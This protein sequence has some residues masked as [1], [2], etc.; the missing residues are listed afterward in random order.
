M[1]FLF[2]GSLLAQTKCA[3]VAQAP[4]LQ[5]TFFGMMQTLV[6]GANNPTVNYF[7]MRTWDQSVGCTWDQI[8]LTP[9]TYTFTNCDAFLDRAQSVGATWSFVFGRTPQQQITTPAN[10][11]GGYVSHGGCAQKPKDLN[12]ANTILPNFVTAIVNHW[13]SRYPGVHFFIECVNE[14]DLARTWAND[15]GTDHGSMADLVTYCTTV[16]T[17]AQAIDPTIVMLGPSSSTYNQFG[18]HLYGGTNAGGNGYLTVAG[19]A[20]SFDVLNL[21]PYFYCPSLP[22]TVPETAIAG[23]TSVTALGVA[24]PVALSETNWGTTPAN[25]GMTDAQRE[26]WIGRMAMY[27]YNFG[28][29]YFWWYQWNCTSGILANCA[30]TMNGS[31][32]G[33]GVA[34][35]FSTLQTWL[36]G[37]QHVPNSCNQNADGHGTWTCAIVLTGNVPAEV[38]FNATGNQT[39][40]VAAGFTTQKNLDGSS[41]S[42]V[43]NSVTAGLIPIMVQ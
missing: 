33:A 6:G 32:V 24:K 17:T 30:G 1:L 42:I 14:G 22:C 25:D 38:L 35:A 10:C 41:S 39:I 28:Y 27:A 16:K 23:N 7:V 40:S 5:S 12:G 13:N 9:G 26:A 20:A 8:E 19:A 4:P 15:A 37:S 2:P 31:G 11:S 34:T 43:G 18:V 36:I 29:I 3:C 21:H